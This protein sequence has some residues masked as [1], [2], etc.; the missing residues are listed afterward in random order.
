MFKIHVLQLLVMIV[1]MLMEAKCRATGSKYEFSS[2]ND[3]L[4]DVQTTIDDERIK[5]IQNS[6]SEG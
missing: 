2:E 4:K 1:R 5:F 6:E 3:Y